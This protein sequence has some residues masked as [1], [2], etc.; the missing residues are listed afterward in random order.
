M[1]LKEYDVWEECQP[2]LSITYDCDM[3]VELHNIF[4]SPPSCATRGCHLFHGITR[5]S[6][7]ECELFD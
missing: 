1:T 5:E 3:C 7:E 2:I 4:R 6:I